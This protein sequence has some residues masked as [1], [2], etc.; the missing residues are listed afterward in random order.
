M[1]DLLGS[2]CVAP[3]F[4]ASSF[5]RSS[6]LPRA[7][8]TPVPEAHLR[9]VE[10]PEGGAPIRGDGPRKAARAAAPPSADA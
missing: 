8:G 7:R 9:R 3:L 5:A 1:G 6:G 10:H 4:G 2:P